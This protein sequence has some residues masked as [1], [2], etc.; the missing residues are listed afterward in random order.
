[1]PDSSNDL[2]GKPKDTSSYLIF[3]LTLRS[4]S[5][6]SDPD[7][8]QNSGQNISQMFCKF[9]SF[10]IFQIIN[11]NLSTFQLLLHTVTVL[12]APSKQKTG[13]AGSSKTLMVTR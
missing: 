9:H 3:Y 1:M 7:F 11:N 13:V 5:T 8:L 2:L 12:P 4:L 6:I 10:V